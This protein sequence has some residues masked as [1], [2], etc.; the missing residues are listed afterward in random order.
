MD[1]TEFLEGLREVYYNHCYYERSGRQPMCG[2]NRA[3]SA[4]SATACRYWRQ[5]SSSLVQC[6]YQVKTAVEHKFGCSCAA[7]R[8]N[9]LWQSSAGFRD[10]KRSDFPKAGHDVNVL[11]RYPRGKYGK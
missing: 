6:H 11:K 4:P 8:R 10:P 5:S 9:A 2:A 7:A 3:A 1:N